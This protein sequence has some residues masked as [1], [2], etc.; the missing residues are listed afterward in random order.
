MMSSL[1]LALLVAGVVVLLAIWAYYR[2]QVKRLSPRRADGDAPAV[3]GPEPPPRR[4]P[5]LDAPL[6]ASVTHAA[7][8]V[9]DERLD[10]IVTLRLDKPV[11]A[12]AVWSVLPGSRRIGSKPFVVEGVPLQAEQPSDQAGGGPQ[13]DWQTLMPGQRYGA[14]RAGIQLANRAGALNEIEYSEFIQKLH[15]WCEH[16]LAAGDP[17]DMLAVVQRARALDQFAAAHDVQLALTVRARRAAWSPGYVAQHASRLGF[18]AGA[19]PGRMVWP[20]SEPG[21]APLLVLQLETQAALAEDP[22]LAVLREVRLVLEVPHV[23][24]NERPFERLRELATALAEAM[25]GWVGDDSGQ[26]LDGAALDRIGQELDRLYE[27]LQ[28]HELPAGSPAARRLFS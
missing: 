2:W 11:T 28:A 16:W 27:T 26:P 8:A 3:M 19:L 22:E 18:V 24:A 17:P 23:P 15:D 4:E 6:P 13:A 14:L 12:E 20:S 25:D 10:A 1:Q 9:L 21:A 5:T 7:P